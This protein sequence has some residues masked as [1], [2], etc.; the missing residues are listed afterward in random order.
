MK[1]IKI[2]VCGMKDRDNIIEV[3]G[4]CPDFI[5]FI[6]YKGSPRY[7]GFEEVQ[8]LIKYIPESIQKVGVLVNE[9]IE[10]AI[11]IAQSGVFNF[12]QLH[13]SE[14]PEYCRILSSHLGVIKSF[15]IFDSFP[16][17]MHYYQPYCSMFLFDTAGPKYGGNGKIFD[18]RIL[19]GYNLETE[20]ILS[21]GLSANDPA[22]IK[23]LSI[24]KMAGVDLN[25]K[26][27]IKPGLKDFNLLK[28]FIEKINRT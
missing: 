8:N 10:N 20:F 3:A 2:K 7:V 19:S 24:S 15:S 11:D 16:V 28:T 1:K 9:P 22:Y 18:H 23:S 14:S 27:E 21:G 17:N 4:L 6:L 12:L 25:S 13:G 5:G 26:F